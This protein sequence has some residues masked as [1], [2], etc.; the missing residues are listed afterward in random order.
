MHAWVTYTSR[1]HKVVDPLEI[2]YC[3][4][5]SCLHARLVRDIDTEGEGTI[6][7]VC[8]YILSR[9]RC[10]VCSFKVDVCEDNSRG[11]SLGE[12][13]SCFK[14]DSAAGAYGGTLC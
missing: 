10:C 4:L 5:N 13:K 6:G 14:A 1:I 3:L 9:I 2:V 12:G 11:S 7:G 8:R